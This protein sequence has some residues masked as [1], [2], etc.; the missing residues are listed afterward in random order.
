MLLSLEFKGLL[1]EHKGLYRYFF[2]FHEAGRKVQPQSRS[3]WSKIRDIRIV[4]AAEAR[5]DKIFWDEKSSICS[6]FIFLSLKVDKNLSNTTSRE[7]FIIHFSNLVNTRDIWSLSWIWYQQ[8]RVV[9]A[10]LF[11][12]LLYLNFHHIFLFV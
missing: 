11:R 12:V 2:A 6:S 4:N 9:Q 5:Q 1:I 7:I 10:S 3:I 8:S